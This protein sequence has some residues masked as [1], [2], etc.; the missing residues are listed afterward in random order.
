MAETGLAQETEG[1]TR[2][3]THTHTHTRTNTHTHTH[4]RTHIHTQLDK[5]AMCVASYPL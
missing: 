1:S 3:M 5:V 4:A 2:E